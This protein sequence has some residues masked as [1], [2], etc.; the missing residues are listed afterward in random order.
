MTEELATHSGVVVGI[1]FNRLAFKTTGR[2]IW[3]EVARI[4]L[5]LQSSHSVFKN[6]HV[7]ISSVLGIYF[8]SKRR[9]V[10]T[11]SHS[12]HA[13]RSLAAHT[14]PNAQAKTERFP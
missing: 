4:I 11:M 7:F 8:V 1:A 2:W 6:F 9:P 5:N 12:S 13:E 3:L 10:E 14:F